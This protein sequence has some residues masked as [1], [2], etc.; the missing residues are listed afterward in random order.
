MYSYGVVLLE[1]VTGQR[2]S[3]LTATGTGDADV[4]MRQLVWTIR[5]KLKSGD[6]SWITHF[7]DPK[8]NDIIVHSEVLLM[9]EVAGMCL[10]KERSQRPSMND[11]V[12][13]SCTQKFQIHYCNK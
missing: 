4:A 1:L 7:V 6:L 10:E 9:L 8:L 5:Q 2:A 13:L 11:I 3:E 12:D